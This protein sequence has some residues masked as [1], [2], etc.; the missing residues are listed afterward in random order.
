M[1]C[2]PGRDELN[3]SVKEPNMFHNYETEKVTRKAS[4][5]A[6]QKTC[7]CIEL[8]GFSAQDRYARRRI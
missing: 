1:N 4:D 6:W 8:F 2:T 3:G 5:M 7:N